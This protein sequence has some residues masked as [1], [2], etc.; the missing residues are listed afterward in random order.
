MSN[1]CPWALHVSCLRGESEGPHEHEAGDWG[2][3]VGRV[4]GEGPVYS[5][6][7]RET[8]SLLVSTAWAAP[9]PVELGARDKDSGGS[10]QLLTCREPDLAVSGALHSPK[11]RA[12][13]YPTCSWGQLFLSADRGAGRGPQQSQGDLGTPQRTARSIQGLP[14]LHQGPPSGFGGSGHFR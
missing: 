10:G 12:W 4:R 3:R 7:P 11:K 13:Q 14:H 8:H 9:R 2:W 1:P 6:R 5:L